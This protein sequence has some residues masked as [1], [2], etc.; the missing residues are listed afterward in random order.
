MLERLHK[1]THSH[2]ELCTNQNQRQNL[3]LF[4]QL[5]ANVPEEVPRAHRPSNYAE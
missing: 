4:Y 2:T 5:L 1:D 3:P